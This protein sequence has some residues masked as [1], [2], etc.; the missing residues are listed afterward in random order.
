MILAVS[1]V[2]LLGAGGLSTSRPFRPAPASAQYDQCGFQPVG[3]RRIEFRRHISCRE[4][5]RVLRQLKGDRDTVPMAC[6]HPRVVRGWRLKNP[7]R[8]FGVVWTDYR[9]GKVSF[10]YRRVDHVGR[11]AWCPPK[12]ESFGHEGV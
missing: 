6:G 7:E 10:T 11:D 9:R 1:V 12:H 3:D 4:A 2:C 5:K 8:D